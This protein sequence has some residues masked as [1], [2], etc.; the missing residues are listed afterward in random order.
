MTIHSAKGLEFLVGFVCG[1]VFGLLPYVSLDMMMMMMSHDESSPE[2]KEWQQH[3]EEQRRLFYVAL[4]RAQF[5]L[6]VS[7][8]AEHRLYGSVDKVKL[9]PFLFELPADS[10]TKKL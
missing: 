9:S 1:V 4:T 2:G 5:H 7:Y 6:F 10:L 8:F 3:I